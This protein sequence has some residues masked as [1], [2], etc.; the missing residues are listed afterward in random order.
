MVCYGPVFSQQWAP[1]ALLGKY[2]F[3]KVG[4]ETV[5][6]WDELHTEEAE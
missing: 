2:V 4:E 6:E 1:E 3:R 5:A